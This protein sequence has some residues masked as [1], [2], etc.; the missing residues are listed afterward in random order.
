MVMDGRDWRE[1]F[2]PP[3]QNVRYPLS[4]PQIRVWCKPYCAV[5][6]VKRL[7]C[8]YIVSCS[9]CSSA[10]AL[11]G[12]QA[13]TGE[14]VQRAGSMEAVR[15]AAAAACAATPSQ[16]AFYFSTSRRCTKLQFAGGA[17]F[18]P[19]TRVRASS[20]E[21]SAS[22][23]SGDGASWIEKFGF[24]N[25][26]NGPRRGLLHHEP[27]W[28]CCDNNGGL[29]GL[30]ERVLEGGGAAAAA[31]GKKRSQQQQLYTVVM[32]FGGSSVAS[33]D[34]MREVA[35]LILSFRD[36]IPIIVMSAMGKTTNNLLKVPFPLTFCRSCLLQKK[37]F[38]QA[39]PFAQA[40]P[41]GFCVFV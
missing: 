33:A 25:C 26:K 17:D 34:R 18:S 16:I 12:F 37:G 20:L 3:G 19:S 14:L 29:V 8:R 4:S 22:I 5:A 41:P 28:V 23:S 27:R 40:K 9:P 35:D 39:D 10:A 2:V 21:W 15:L 32:K 13:C 7:M 31:G 11:A 30:E 1:V 6:L 38:A 36:E 24:C